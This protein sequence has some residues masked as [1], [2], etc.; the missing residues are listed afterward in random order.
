LLTKGRVVRPLESL[1]IDSFAFARD[2]GKLQ[3]EF[4]EAAFER[5]ADQIVGD[6]QGVVGVSLG[7]Y[8]DSEG[9]HS[10]QMS[11]RGCIHLTCQRCLGTLAWQVDMDHELILVR[12][13]DQIP[14]DELEDDVDVIV[15]S[16]AMS[17]L[18]LVEDELIL[19][20]P[21]AP[22]HDECDYPRVS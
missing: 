17:V 13:E 14:D 4:R 11:L 6:K 16:S 20:L 1:T 3:L 19:S 22:M 12:R 8:R 2:G 18:A 15:G 21:V 10:L 5:L 7:G 9:A